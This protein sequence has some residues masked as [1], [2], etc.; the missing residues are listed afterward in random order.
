[1]LS[2]L[3]LGPDAELP[4]GAAVGAVFVR[5]VRAG[6]PSAVLTLALAVFGAAPGAALGGLA[7]AVL[8]WLID[9][10][11]RGPAA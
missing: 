5:G 1:V 11:D 9:R 2:P 8:A 4:S 7:G 10:G 3:A 6:G